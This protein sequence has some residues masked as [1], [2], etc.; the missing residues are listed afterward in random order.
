MTKLK[1][2]NPNYPNGDCQRTVFACLLGYDNPE[3]VPNF[4]EMKNYEKDWVKN[5]NEWLDSKGLIYTEMTF[6]NFSKSPFVPAGLC[7]IVGKSPRGDYNHIVIGK[8]KYRENGDREL[9]YVWDTSPYH[10][11]KFLDDIKYI[12]FLSQKIDFN[13][14]NVLGKLNKKD[15]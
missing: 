2:L 3:M 12:G 11:G 6:D 5:I 4:T 13:M 15:K 10:N 9:I 7:T 8:I 14:I 1:Q